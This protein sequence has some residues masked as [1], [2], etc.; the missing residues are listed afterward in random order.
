MK[1]TKTKTKTKRK[2][3]SAWPHILALIQ[4]GYLTHAESVVKAEEYKIDELRK[5]I[6]AIKTEYERLIIVI[7]EQTKIIAAMNTNHI[8]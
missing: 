5:E 4:D 8:K 6:T 1:K 3:F 7:N 2:I